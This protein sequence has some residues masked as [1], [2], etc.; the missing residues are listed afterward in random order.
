MEDSWTAPPS[1][2]QFEADVQA[3][4]KRS[5]HLPVR[6]QTNPEEDRESV[7]LELADVPFLKDLDGP[8]LLQERKRDVELLQ[9][10]RSFLFCWPRK[11]LDRKVCR[12]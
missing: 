10:R 8:H 6:I 4:A 3:A 12:Q 5:K 9:K 2:E 11:K 1:P 7:Q